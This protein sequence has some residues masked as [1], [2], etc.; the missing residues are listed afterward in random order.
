M[1]FHSVVSYCV[2][3]FVGA[4]GEVKL[5]SMQLTTLETELKPVV[6]TLLKQVNHGNIYVPKGNSIL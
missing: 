1:V 6:E 5:G 3:S 4:R 2:I